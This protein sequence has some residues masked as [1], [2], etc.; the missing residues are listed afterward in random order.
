MKTQKELMLIELQRI[1]V[2]NEFRTRLLAERLGL[3]VER[4]RHVAGEL[5]D[6]GAL[7]KVGHYWWRVKRVDVDIRPPSPPQWSLPDV[8]A[9]GLGM[10][11]LALASRPL[12]VLAFD[13]A[14]RSSAET[15]E[16]EAA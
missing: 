6:A 4:T 10:V 1:G 11:D 16:L 12:L 15:E 13:A 14:V 9:E 3:S 8:E 2:G 7:E 5:V